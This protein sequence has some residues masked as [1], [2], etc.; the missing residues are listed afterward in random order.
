MHAPG[1]A[2]ATFAVLNSDGFEEANW[3]LLCTLGSVGPGDGESGHV[4]ALTDCASQNGGDDQPLVELFV[5]SNP[6]STPIEL[7]TPFIPGRWFTLRGAASG[8]LLLAGFDGPSLYPWDQP[9]FD[10][11]PLDLELVSIG[12]A[13]FEHDS[14]CGLAERQGLEVGFDRDVAT[15][16][17]GNFGYVG[18]LVSYQIIVDELLDFP[19]LTCDDFPNQIL[20]A[21]VFSIPE[22]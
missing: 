11:A 10:Y 9:G 2:F 12:C 4:I 1:E 7:V 19:E 18:E 5:D 22:G 20:T 15:I 21:L 8:T 13:P 17:D 3:D 6:A 14:Q 16:S